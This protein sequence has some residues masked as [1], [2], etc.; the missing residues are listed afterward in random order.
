MIR[1]T[2]VMAIGLACSLP[3][4]SA[5]AAAR[6]R[7]FV[8]SYGND[9]NPCTFGSP[10]KTFQHAHDVVADGGEVT[11]ID[12]AGFG[13]LT[14]DHSVTITSPEGVEAGIV[15]TAGNNA[16][17]INAA[18]SVTV[19][20]RG[21]TLNG[22][23]VAYNG[24]VFEGTGGGSLTVTNCTV[25]NFVQNGS[26]ATTGN[27]I[28]MRA[29]DGTMNF[30]ITNT[31]VSSN[32]YSGISYFP[33]G[34]FPSANGV[35]DR[36]T[37]TGNADGIIINMDNANGGVV[38]TA[39]SNSLASDNS[40]YGI[41]IDNLSGGILTVSIDN[42]S[43]ARNGVGNSGAGISAANVAN[44]LLGRSVITGNDTGVINGPTTT[45]YTYLDNRINL[46]DTTDIGGSGLTSLAPQ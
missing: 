41:D 25:Q 38:F 15:A 9:V 12:S 10:C 28:L 1:K 37:A 4:M 7:V 33:Q 24:I 43:A 34:G 26:D 18:S 30:V 8:A 5:H 39:I 31:I 29:S 6:D 27:G 2:I 45:F 3:A 32:G 20:L 44:A 19:V 22:S 40:K 17:T 42:T 13:P 16:V 46:N 35:I 21:L 36:V 14:I 23:G 11:A